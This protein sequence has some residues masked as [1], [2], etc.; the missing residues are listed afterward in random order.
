MESRFKLFQATK[1]LGAMAVT[2]M[3]V[4]GCAT[5]NPPG[6]KAGLGATAVAHR[7]APVDGRKVF[8]REA[9]SR[10]NPTIVLLHGFPSSSHMYRDLIPRLADRF[11]VIAPDYIG[12]GYS[13]APPVTEFRYTFDQLA[14]VVDRLL[15][16]LKVND[17]VLY[18]QD[19]GGPVGFR[20]ATAH[21]ERVKGLV[22]QN[23]NAYK[24]GLSD[25][26]KGFFGPL[27]KERNEKTVGAV[28]NLI[29]LDGTKF[30]YLTGTRS[31][32]RVS[33]DAWMHDQARLDRPGSLERQL[34]LFIDYEKNIGLY[35][36]WHAYLRKHQPKTLVVW[37]KGDPFFTV[38]GAEAYRKDLKQVELHVLNTGHFALEEDA[39]VVADLIRRTFE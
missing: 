19:Y 39:P 32:E 20:L 3:L 33:P 37:G 30:Q 5:Q 28:R 26:A 7:Y 25:V 17:Y 4:A 34:A 38:A 22:I 8:Y 15:A 16:G 1:V 11:H 29:T 21:P 10:N 31:P 27:W 9:G 14:S 13:D 35:D 6:A 36:A 18:M 23:A 24:D 12:F 2:G